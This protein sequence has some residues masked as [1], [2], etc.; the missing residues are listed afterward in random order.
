MGVEN[1]PRRYDLGLGDGVGAS[2]IDEI[3]VA[4]EQRG[5]IRLSREC[6][7][8]IGLGMREDGEVYIA[9]RPGLVARHGTEKVNR[10]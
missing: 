5:E 4:L 9:V 1:D 2:Q 8:W 7:F 6:H 3:N 10:F